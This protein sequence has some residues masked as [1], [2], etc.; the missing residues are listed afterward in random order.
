M[1]RRIAFLLISGQIFCMQT[2]IWSAEISQLNSAGRVP[3]NCDFSGMKCEK[4]LSW[5]EST[6]KALTVNHFPMNI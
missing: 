1:K 4:N 3:D 6:L 5:N 2:L